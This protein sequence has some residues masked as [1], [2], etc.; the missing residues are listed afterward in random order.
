MN[1]ARGEYRMG[2]MT[3]PRRY[4]LLGLAIL[5]GLVIGGTERSWAETPPG[6]VLA[7][8]NGFPIKQKDLEIELRQF[9]ARASSHYREVDPQHL[10][11]L[12]QKLLGS[13]II[14]ELLYQ[15]SQ[16]QDIYVDP[17][18]VDAQMSQWRQRFDSRQAFVQALGTLGLDV[19]RART[20]VARRLAVQQLLEVQILR[21]IRVTPKESRHFYA[22]HPNYFKQPEQIKVRQI[23]I[24][25]DPKTTEIQKA[26]ARGKIEYV[27]ER[28]QAGDDF[29]T[30]AR[31]YS[32]APSAKLG[33]DL[34]FV[35]RQQLQKRLAETAFAL[36]RGEIS[37]IVTSKIGYH[38]LQVTQQRNARKLPFDQVQARLEQRMHD[39]KAQAAI[40]TYIRRL[41]DNAVVLRY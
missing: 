40:G 29:G 35:S 16:R 1:M 41:Q 3:S 26:E 11:A 5:L 24:R 34:G 31:Q 38:I 6:T 4:I 37:P 2:L 39:E 18:A 23:L 13:L 25:A 10:P 7:Q 17:A 27:L 32:E 36:R 8:V 21:H 19:Q 20:Q 9:S 30:L 28:L 33:G 22:T 15:E 12:R 14:R